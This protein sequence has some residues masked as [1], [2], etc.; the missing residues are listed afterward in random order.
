[1]TEE[2]SHYA[3]DLGDMYVVFPSTYS[4][5]AS[6]Y[7]DKF[8]KCKIGNYSSHGI[9][10]IDKEKVRKILLDEGLI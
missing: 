8:Q 3:K 1:M 5:F 2:E 10:E 4:E 6:K 7:Y 9:L